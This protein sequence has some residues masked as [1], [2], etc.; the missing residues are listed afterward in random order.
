MTQR[1]WSR[2][3]QSKPPISW[4]GSKGTFSIVLS[5]LRDIGPTDSVAA[6]WTPPLMYIV[7]IREAGS[8]DWGI[9][10]ET[11]LR[12]CSFVDLKPNTK[13]EVQIRAKNAVGE[14]EPAVIEFSAGPDG[15][16]HS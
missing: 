8:P 14:S 10:F 2:A 11:P 4:D 16:L 13:Y 7:R 6:E 15:T 1:R 9:G 3:S 12:G 5:G